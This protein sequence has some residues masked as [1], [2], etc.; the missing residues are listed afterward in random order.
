MR[1]WRRLLIKFVFATSGPIISSSDSNRVNQEKR[2]SC[3]IVVS[4]VETAGS[5]LAQATSAKWLSRFVMDF[6]WVEWKLV[7]ELFT[8]FEPSI[9]RLIAISNWLESNSTLRS[10]KN[11]STHYLN[12]KLSNKIAVKQKTLFHSSPF[13]VNHRLYTLYPSKCPSELSIIEGNVIH[14]VFDNKNK[15]YQRNHNFV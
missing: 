7:F 12:L 9:H 13:W 11:T 2:E 15:G 8:V 3:A 10:A 4:Y 6:N 5:Y 14:S 1:L